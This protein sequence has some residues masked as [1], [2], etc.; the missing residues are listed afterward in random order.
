VEQGILASDIQK[1]PWPDGI[2]PLILKK[3]GLVV[4]KSLAILLIATC[5]CFLEVFH[6]LNAGNCKSISFSSG[7]KPV[8]FQCHW[9]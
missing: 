8:I 6:H 9:R 5:R 7:S 4:K 1:G 3:I 2:S